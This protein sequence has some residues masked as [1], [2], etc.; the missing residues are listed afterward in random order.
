[1]R[2]SF[3]VRARSWCCVFAG[4]CESRMG[5]GLIKLSAAAMDEG[6]R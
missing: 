3:E 4:E 2:R 6:A 1:M 5:F